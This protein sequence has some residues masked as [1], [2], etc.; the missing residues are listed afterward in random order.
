MIVAHTPA[1]LTPTESVTSTGTERESVN[2]SVYLRTET[3]RTAGI[4]T[5]PSP[6]AGVVVYAE[7]F[8]IYL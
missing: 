1:R 5:T 3:G 2:G 6:P 8:L 4:T 7:V